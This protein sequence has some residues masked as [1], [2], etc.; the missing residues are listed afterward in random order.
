MAAYG[1]GALD[2]PLEGILATDGVASVF[3]SA[4]ERAQG[5][6]KREWQEM[7]KMLEELDFVSG[8]RVR[9]SA[10][11]TSPLS[12]AAAAE[13][14]ASVTLR[15]TGQV[16][17]TP[18]QS[19]T[20]ANLVGRGLGIDKSRLVISD[21]AGRSLYDGEQRGSEG[22]EVADLLAHQVE[23]DRRLAREATA[24]LEQILGPNKA[25][26]SVTSEWDYAQSTLRKDT[27]G[28]GTVVQETKST[29]E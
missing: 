8:A 7:E 26:V 16:E 14:T 13:G 5:V 11:P 12:G 18:A 15:L 9:T 19:E 29:S 20:I 21:Q 10:V 23:H 1:A 3:S 27:T 28:K 25:R 2:K 22:T 6:R 4:E 24:V 17:L